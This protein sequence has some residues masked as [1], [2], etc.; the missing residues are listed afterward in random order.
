MNALLSYFLQAGICSGILYGY[1]HFFLRNKRFH[2]YNRFYLLGSVLLSLLVPLLNIPVYFTDADKES[3]VVL[4]TLIDLSPVSSSPVIRDVPMMTERAAGTDLFTLLQ[5]GYLFIVILAFL[6]VIVSLYRIWQLYRQHPVERLEKIRFIHT[7]AP[8]TPFS[9][10]R[11]LFWDDRIDLHS[12]KGNQVFRH[13]LFHIRQRHSIDI[14]C[15]EIITALGWLNPFFHLMKKE[16]KAIHEFLA[17]RFAITE[18]TRWEYAE[19]LLMQAFNTRNSLVNPFFHNQIKR[20]IAMITNPSKPGSQY[21]RKLLVLP[22]A[23]ILMLIFAFNYKNSQQ[24][25]VADNNSA[26]DN[27]FS[28]DRMLSAD[29]S[30]PTVETDNKIFAKVE[31][32]SAF[33]GGLPQWRSFLEKNLNAGIPAAKGAPAGAYTVIIQFVVDKEGRVGDLKA[34]TNHGYGMEAEAL[35]VFKLSPNWIPAR[36]NGRVVT[37]YRKQPVTFLVTEDHQSGTASP[38]IFPGGD[39]AWTQFLEKNLNA[40][41]PVEN[42][43][44]DG[45]YKVLV[46]FLVDKNGNISKIKARTSHGFKMEEELERML[47]SSPAWIPA[48]RNGKPVT[49]YHNQPVTFI[50]GNGKTVHGSPPPAENVLNEVVLVS[51]AKGAD[52]RDTDQPVTANDLYPSISLEKIKSSKPYE[53]LQVSPDTE[54][55]GFMFTTDLNDNRIAESYN[56]GDQYSAATVKL[57]NNLNV[58]RLVTLD[59]I[60]IKKDGKEIKIASKVYNIIP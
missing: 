30:K 41:I 10:F 48:T 33:P 16:L 1:Y 58:G 35:R 45:I 38:A 3:S 28:G 44:P 49:S 8:G 46:E 11:W 13:E 20:R 57:I 34:L 9:F 15:M 23:A 2:Q 31:V 43:A 24:N 32:E 29:T 52:S 6:R 39:A 12:A 59:L 47:K 17:D 14:V 25:E 5:Y 56:T 60:K 18:N 53:L 27:L 51:F 7:S 37:A 54:I 50:V 42:K 40:R 4:N 19:L 26:T 22:L 21:L 55:V 36:Q